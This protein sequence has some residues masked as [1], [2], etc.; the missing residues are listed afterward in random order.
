[1][2]RLFYTDH[3]SLPL[4]PLHKFPMAKYRLVREMLMAD[5]RFAVVRV[6]ELAHEREYVRAFLAGE[7]DAAAMRKI[8]FP[9]SEGLVQRTLASVGGTLGATND[10]FARGWGG[11]LAGGS[12]HA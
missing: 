6:I 9:W 11:T 2:R 10:A 12:H 3:L 4:P 8:G 7:L 1:M 5:G